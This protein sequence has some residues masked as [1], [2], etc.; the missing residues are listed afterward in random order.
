[1][2]SQRLVKRKDGGRVA[3]VEVMLNTPYIAE[4]ILKGDIDE[5]REAMKDSSD[6]RM[7]TFDDALYKLYHD[8]VIDL[9]EA[10]GNADSAT[11]LETRIN[12]GTG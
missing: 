10:L 2:I 12:F 4:L 5:V 3:A 11:N 6:T 7:Q 1:M 8:G 9:D